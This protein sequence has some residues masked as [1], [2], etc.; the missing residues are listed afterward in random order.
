MADQNHQKKA[1]TP[2]MGSRGVTRPMAEKEMKKGKDDGE[3]NGMDRMKMLH[4]HHKQTLWIYWLLILLGAWLVVSPFSFDYG[5]DI[6][7]PSGGRSVWL[8]DAMR[9]QIMQWSDIICGLLLMFFGWRSLTPNRPISLWI[10][11][12][13][14]IWLNFAPVIL[15]TQCLYL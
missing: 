15:G 1:E 4:M 13:V 7:Q 11:C 5:K 12:F 10:A 9:V 8:S 6:M 14:G 2:G 3:D